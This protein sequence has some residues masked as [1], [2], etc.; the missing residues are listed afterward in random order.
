M[1]AFMRLKILGTGRVNTLQDFVTVMNLGSYIHYL[2]SMG[3]HR[4]HGKI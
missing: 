3:T 2:D 1:F 4:R